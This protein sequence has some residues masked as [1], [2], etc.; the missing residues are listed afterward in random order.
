LNFL[1][2]LVLA[3]LLAPAARDLEAQAVVQPAP[4]LDST[5][6]VIQRSVHSLRDSLTVVQ[7]ASARIARDIRTTSDAVLRARARQMAAGCSAASRASTSTRVVVIG[8]NRPEPD[9]RGLRRGMEQALDEL[10]AQLD[11]CVV[12]F[13]GLVTPARA[14]ELRDYGIGRGLKVQ[15]AIRRYELTVRSYF[16]GATGVRYLPGQRG[17]ETGA[18]SD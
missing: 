11:R 5:Q 7:A 10:K 15:Q 8:A 13:Q 6:S 16:F 2:A 3:T 4:T 9:P 1:K 14:Q 18:V 17:R 12:E